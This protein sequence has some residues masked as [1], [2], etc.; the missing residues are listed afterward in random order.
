M[1]LLKDRLFKLLQDPRVVTLM[2][3]PKVQ[4]AVVKALRLR[5][6]VEGAMNQQVQRIA[7]VLNLATQRDLRTLH[8]K[9]RHLERELREAQEQI[10]EAEDARAARARS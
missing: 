10:I 8:R 4:Q 9:V 3:D 7:N 2:Q 1:T 5:G 6:R